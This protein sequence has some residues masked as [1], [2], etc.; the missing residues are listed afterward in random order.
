MIKTILTPKNEKLEL[1]GKVSYNES[2]QSW[3]TIRLR[4]PLLREFPALLDKLND[5]YYYIIF[6]RNYKE[7]TKN[8]EIMKKGNHPLPLLLFFY[9]M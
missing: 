4:K 9:K 2:E 3:N 7:L 8:I 1:N 5:I 6:F